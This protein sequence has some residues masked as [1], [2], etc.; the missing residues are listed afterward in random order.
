MSFI[1]NPEL[2][3]ESLPPNLAEHIAELDPEVRDLLERLRG[4][5]DPADLELLA[6]DSRFW[7]PAARLDVRPWLVHW[8]EP[9]TDFAVD[10]NRSGPILDTSSVGCAWS[11][12]GVHRR[13][14][15]FNGLTATGRSVVVRGYTVMGE[16]RGSFGF[17]RYI[18]WAGLYGQLGLTVNW[19]VPLPNA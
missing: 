19:R 5:A 7:F 2:Q 10:G 12:G 9:T 11:Y 13:D 8:F 4:G 16:E 18:D 15:R 6:S 17:A 1:D 14:G 3:P